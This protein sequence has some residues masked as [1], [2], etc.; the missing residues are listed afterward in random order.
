MSV[1]TKYCNNDLLFLD[2]KQL[3]KIMKLCYLKA[4][5]DSQGKIKMYYGTSRVK[6]QLSQKGLFCHQDVP[7]TSIR[8]YKLT[9]TS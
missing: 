4:M 6:K 8:G 3:I 2:V 5:R 1:K 9:T 7:Q